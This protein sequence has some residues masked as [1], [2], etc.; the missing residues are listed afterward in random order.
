MTQHA[1]TSRTGLA[2]TALRVPSTG[3]ELVTAVCAFH[4]RS[5]P[6][7]GLAARL[8]SRAFTALD[9]VPLDVRLYVHDLQATAEEWPAL[10]ITLPPT[11][12]Q[13][14]TLIDDLAALVTGLSA[15]ELREAAEGLALTRGEVALAY[16][17]PTLAGGWPDGDEPLLDT[18]TQPRGRRAREAE[19][20]QMFDHVGPHDWTPEQI[21]AVRKA[22]LIRLSGLGDALLRVSALPPAT[23]DWQADGERLTARVPVPGAPQPLEAQVAA[24]PVEPHPFTSWNDPVWGPTDAAASRERWRWSVGWRSADGAFHTDT[25]STEATEAAARFGAEQTLAAYAAQAPIVR[26]RLRY[27]LLVPRQPDTLAMSDPAVLV[28]GLRPLLEAVCDEYRSEASHQEPATGW[29]V[30]PHQ[31]ENQERSL[32]AIL[33]DDCSLPYPEL[34]DPANDADPASA[35][36]EDFLRSHAVI[37]TPPARAYL[38]GLSHAG[39]GELPL[40][41]RH[42]AAMRAVFAVGGEAADLLAAEAGPLPDGTAWIDLLDAAALEEFLAATE[43]DQAP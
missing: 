26:Q 41:Q 28:L 32:V 23:L 19:L 39:P 21:D 1:P 6:G 38:A 12:W 22:L 34:G 18:A 17:S 43:S 36:F 25:G 42:E 14:A 11:P 30:L 3:R 2:A 29:R 20:L 24:V 31:D 4:G 33:L 15:A 35:A 13:A 10:P 5:A 9:Q 40:R 16:D 37:L 8:V 27:R 7:P